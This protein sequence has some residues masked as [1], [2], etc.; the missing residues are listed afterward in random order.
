MFLEL[1]LALHGKIGFIDRNMGAYR[2]HGGGVWMGIPP[3]QKILELLYRFQLLL[4]DPEIRES[5]GE[6]INQRVTKLESG[7][8]LKTEC[9]EFLCKKSIFYRIAWF[10][11]SG[12]QFVI[13]NLRN[14]NRSIF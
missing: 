14:I 10:F 6:Q 4:D 12:L 8:I 11:D 2:K 3:A 13:R 1:Q 9:S 5:Y 7:F